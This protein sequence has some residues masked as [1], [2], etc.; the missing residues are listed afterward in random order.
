MSRL[1]VHVY[2]E[3]VRDIKIAAHGR[4]H[5]ARTPFPRETPEIRAKIHELKQ[6]LYQREHYAATLAGQGVD[7]AKVR[8]EIHELEDQISA[9]MQQAMRRDSSGEVTPPS[10]TRDRDA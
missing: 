8:G 6:R 3:W 1:V 5:D 9:L 4:T 2:N 7:V 10:N